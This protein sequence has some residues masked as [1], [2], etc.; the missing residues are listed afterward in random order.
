MWREWRKS[1]DTDVLLFLQG[2]D[3]LRKGGLI[4]AGGLSHWRKVVLRNAAGRCGDTREPTD[5][6]ESLLCY[7]GGS[8]T[9]KRCNANSSKMRSLNY[10]AS[11]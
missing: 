1:C 2:G 5:N 7:S 6:C 4:A 11:F 3:D 9:M 8:Q 10:T